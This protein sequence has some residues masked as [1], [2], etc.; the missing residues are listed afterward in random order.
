M[1]PTPDTRYSAA[2]SSFSEIKSQG[3]C[4][5]KAPRIADVLRR[6]RVE[7][8]ALGEWF[9]GSTRRPAGLTCADA[10]IGSALQSTLSEN[11]AASRKNGKRGFV[12]ILN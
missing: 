7:R 4:D 1:T 5:R 12:T 3:P 8:P 11:Y 10:S 6:V 2:V 9:P